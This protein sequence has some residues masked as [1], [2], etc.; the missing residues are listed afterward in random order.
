EIRNGRD[1]HVIR[2][3]VRGRRELVHHGGDCRLLLQ[4]LAWLTL[5]RHRAPPLI[6]Y[7]LRMPEEP[8]RVTRCSRIGNISMAPLEQRSASVT[9]TTRLGRN[10]KYAGRGNS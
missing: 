2:V 8:Y 6:F 10:L 1:D 7:R 3:A 9:V 4:C 5:M